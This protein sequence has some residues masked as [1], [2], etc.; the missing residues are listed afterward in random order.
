[1]DR[2]SQVLAQGVPPG[3][4]RSYR[5]LA[6]HGNVPHST[7]HH[8]ACGRPLIEDKARGQQYLKP[9]EE[10]VVVKYLLQMSDLGQLIRI[11][12]IPSIAFRVTRHRP[13][14]DRPLK[15]PGR[16][17]TKALEK[18]HPELVARRV[19]A[20]DWNRYERNTYRK[21]TH[22]F[23]VIKDVLQDP[24]VLAEN[25]YN[26]DETGVM[27]SMLGS[28]KVLVSKHDIRDYRGARVKRITVTTV[29]GRQ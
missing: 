5:A 11:K 13:T 24:A 21:I 29:T 17:W 27:L 22:W 10:D 15:P 28:V 9:Y 18:R 4:P 25:V 3:V 8:R 1:M 26:M 23:E 14:T 2:V 16:N 12:F 6:D 20:L 19:K 7:L